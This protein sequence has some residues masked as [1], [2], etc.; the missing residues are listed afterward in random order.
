[1]VATRSQ[2]QNCL[3]T[4]GS[5]FVGRHLVSQLLGTG[6]CNVTVFDIRDFGDSR[7]KGIVGDLRRLEDVTQACAGTSPYLAK[8]MFSLQMSPVRH[9]TR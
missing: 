3:V 5:G 8:S 4:G 7:V 1:M 2:K 6:K 9:F